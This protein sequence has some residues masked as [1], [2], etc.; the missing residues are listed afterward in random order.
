MSKKPMSWKDIEIKAFQM[1][2]NSDPTRRPS[3]KTSFGSP[4]VAYGDSTV[5]SQ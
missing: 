3:T 2:E 4:V 5:V 1:K